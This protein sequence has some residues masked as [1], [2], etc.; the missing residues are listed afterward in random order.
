MSNIC[1][2]DRFL[3]PECNLLHFTRN[4]GITNLDD[5]EGDDTDTYL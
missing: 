3:K 5:F 4:L 2:F 1:D